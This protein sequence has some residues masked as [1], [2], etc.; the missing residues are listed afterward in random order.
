MGND[1]VAGLRS[2]LGIIFVS[3]QRTENIL[4]VYKLMPK[5]Y[6]AKQK[7]ESTAVNNLTK[8]FFMP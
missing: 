2:A 8:Q 3:K 7:Y 6:G 5:S 4:A 1:F